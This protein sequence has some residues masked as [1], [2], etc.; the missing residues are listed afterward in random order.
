MCDMAKKKAKAFVDNNFELSEFAPV[1]YAAFCFVL[2]A[3]II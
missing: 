3:G 1:L 2:G